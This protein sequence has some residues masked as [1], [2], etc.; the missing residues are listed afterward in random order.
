MMPETFFN[1]ERL[2]RFWFYVK[3]FMAFNMPIFMI[4]MGAL[5]VGLIL[6]AII[7]TMDS[8]RKDKDDDDIETHYY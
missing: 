3:W 2:A 4:C 6:D 8:A 5:V 7:E 1:A